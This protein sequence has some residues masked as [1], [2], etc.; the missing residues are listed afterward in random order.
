MAYGKEEARD[1]QVRNLTSE[2]V[3][4]LEASQNLLL[5]ISTV[6]FDHHRIP[7]HSDLGVAQRPILHDLGGP[8]AVPPVDY[9]HL[10]SVLGQEVGLLHGRVATADHRKGLVAE[11]GGGA[12]AHSASRN[13]TVPE[14][15]FAVTG[16]REGEALG[17]GAGGDDDGVGENGLGIGEDL[18]GGGG[19]IDARDGLG[20]DLGA[21]AEGLAPAAVHELD[22]KDALWETGEILDVGGGGELAAGGD[23][24]G[25]PALEEDGLEFGTSGVDGCGVGGG[26]TPDDA[27]LSL[28]GLEAVHG[29]RGLGGG[30]RRS[31]GGGKPKPKSKSNKA[32]SFFEECFEAVWV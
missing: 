26:A 22:A 5:P 4:D 20:E 28:E 9:V 16:S 31:G 24:V 30:E 17:D 15:I 27:N 13:T 32:S 18:E 1:V 3:L 19:E 14:P 10:R 7:E 8:E 29:G 25:H 12:V 11:D 23:V 6:G 21:E 2:Q